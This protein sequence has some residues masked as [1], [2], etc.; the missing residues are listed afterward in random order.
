MTRRGLQLNGQFRYLFPDV[1][2]EVDAEI[3]P[4]RITNTNRYGLTWKHNQAIS[5]IPGLATYV[6][7]QKV[8]DDAYFTDLSD[9]LVVTSQQTLPR[10]AGI[11]YNRGPFSF[12]AR[13][14]AFQTLQDP[15]N[16]IT[17]PYFREPQLLADDEPGRVARHRFRRQRRIRALP[18]AGAAQCRAGRDLSDGNV[19]DA[20][21]RVVRHRARR[22][23]PEPLRFRR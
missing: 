15:N 4:D 5:Q 23:A 12:L 1:T 7:V 19:D 11:T 8:S 17:P 16:P 6:N 2:G 3:L 18:P 21:Q 14:Q 13:A 20:R 10:E 22:A 9:R